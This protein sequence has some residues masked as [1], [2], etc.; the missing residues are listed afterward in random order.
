MY[1]RKKLNFQV[2]LKTNFIERS[3]DRTV[4]HF[5]QLAILPC[6]SSVDGALLG[7]RSFGAGSLF[8]VLFMFLVTIVVVGLLL[9][10]GSFPF[11]FHLGS[12]H[13]FLDIL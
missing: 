3:T 12:S 1:V 5:P 11:G 6:M 9:T 7:T 2:F 10:L 8:S 4:S 13:P